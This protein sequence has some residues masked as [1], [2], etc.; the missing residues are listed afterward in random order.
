MQARVKI[1]F[2]TMRME[3]MKNMRRRRGISMQLL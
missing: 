1:V 2:E 3:V